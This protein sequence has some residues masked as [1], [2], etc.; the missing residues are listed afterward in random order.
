MNRRQ[1]HLYVFG[2]FRLDPAEQILLREG[3]PVSL[4][5]K[6]FE[7]LVALVERG[8]RL[9]MKD[10]LLREVWPDAFVEEGSLARNIHELRKTLGEVA[11]ENLYIET[12]PKRGYRFVAPV[13]DLGEEG[14]QLILR[15]RIRAQIIPEEEETSP[16]TEIESAGGSD[17]GA[18]AAADEQAEVAGQSKAGALAPGWLATRRRRMAAVAALA[19]AVVF[20]TFVARQRSAGG[21]ETIDSVAVLPFANADPKVEYLSNGVTESI[22]NS[23]SQLP[24]LRVV[25]RS[26]VF[27]YKGRQ[28][29][30][31]AVAKELGVRAVLAGEIK[32]Q[33]DTLTIRTEMID[34]AR[35]SQLWGERYDRKLSDVLDVQEKIA[36]A[37]SEKLRPRLTREDQ[38]RLVRHYPTNTEAFQAYLKGRYYWNQRTEEGLQKSIEYFQQAIEIDP[39][40]AIA[41]S[42]LADSYTTLGYFSYV[43]PS[44]AFPRA[45]A[46]ALRALELDSGLAE[47]H[48][49][50]AYAELYYDWNWPKAEEEF[51]RAI[52]ANPNYATAH[53]WYSVYL[54]AMG[55]HEEA[56]VEIKR[57]QELDPLSLAINTDIG[58]ELYY[59]RQ[60][61][62]AIGQLHTVLEMNPNFPLAHLWLG[63]AYQQKGMYDEAIAE[64]K[65]VE[66]VFQGWPVAIA[67]EGQAAGVAGKR[68]E[69]QK[70]LNELHD[71]S[72]Q[73]YVTAY[74]VALV[75]AGRGQNDEAFAWLD[76]AFDERS[77]WLVWLRLDPRWEGLRS[78]T[79]FAKLEQ[80]LGFPQ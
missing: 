56:Y 24:G 71:L 48:T 49:S 44:E 46:A 25:P 42:G 57:A 67:A 13:R 38:Q 35:D 52:G 5:P 34:A 20:A 72:K 7:T 47:P 21:D 30:P 65:K 77:H 60:Y 22:I 6:A 76:R 12:V 10:E 27:R 8:G 31:Q 69:A 68:D 61:D 37:V 28:M 18:H 29:D 63:R 11:S 58:F 50:Y 32:Y 74:G 26:T 43:A 17:D 14:A 2:P 39:T 54:T 41:Y 4:T 45:K 9:V 40:Y 55:R 66:A 70:V 79:R 1:S 73:R 53:H 15:Q 62:Q 51:K 33:D 23:L 3:E 19:L 36:R 16:P 80:R 78:D 75:H 59:Q 64:F